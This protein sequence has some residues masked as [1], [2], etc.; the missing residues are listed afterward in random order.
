MQLLGPIAF[1]AS[2]SLKGASNP[3]PPQARMHAL[4]A[5]EED[6][7]SEEARALLSSPQMQSMDGFG[8]RSIE[9][10]GRARVMRVSQVQCPAVTLTL[11]HTNPILTSLPP[12]PASPRW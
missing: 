12:A 2:F 1:A 10:H 5:A 4:L 11:Q 3:L 6:P 9:L 8:S 7:N